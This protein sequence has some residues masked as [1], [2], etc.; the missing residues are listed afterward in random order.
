M[1]LNETGVARYKGNKPERPKMPSL[2]GM[3]GGRSNREEY[4]FFCYNFL[5]VM[6]GKCKWGKA[7]KRAGMVS[8]VATP[9][10]EAMTLL[11]L[12]NNWEYWSF[13][14]N[15]NDDDSDGDET[16]PQEQQRPK[17]Q[18]GKYTTGRRNQ[19]R[20]LCG[21]NDNGISRYNALFKMVKEDRDNDMSSNEKDGFDNFYRRKHQEYS[22]M[23]VGDVPNNGEGCNKHSEEVLVDW[24]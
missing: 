5:T 21:W 11:M 4:A 18:G 15:K 23:P 7:M 1:K 13:Q 20:N 8:T 6:V 14:A 17:P 24:D 10:D 3:L 12:E 16:R 19:A 9:S 22:G 2:E